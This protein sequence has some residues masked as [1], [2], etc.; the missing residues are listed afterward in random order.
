MIKGHVLPERVPSEVAKLE[1]EVAGNVII[2]C[3]LAGTGASL[4]R[5]VAEAHGIAKQ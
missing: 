5:K 4:F 3:E 1:N 2:L